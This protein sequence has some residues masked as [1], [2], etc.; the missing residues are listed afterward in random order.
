MPEPKR[1]GVAV[2]SER[3]LTDRGG[4]AVATQRIATQAAAQRHHQL[5]YALPGREG[6]RIQ[7]LGDRARRARLAGA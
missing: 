7:D 3:S 6:S 1:T 2:L 5:D 4:L